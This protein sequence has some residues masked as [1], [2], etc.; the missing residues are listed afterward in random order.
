MKTRSAALMQAMLDAVVRA[1]AAGAE[2]GLTISA[3][4]VAFGCA[5]VT[6]MT[7]M[8]DLE[9]RDLVRVIGDIA[10]PKG[11]RRHQVYGPTEIAA[12]TKLPPSFATT[13]R[14]QK[15]PGSVAP[16]AA[17][18][19]PIVFRPSRPKTQSGSGVVA[20]KKEIRGYV[21]HARAVQA[22]A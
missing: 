8:K 20:G 18:A 22:D 21:W 17:I 4:Q 6:A 16:V 13:A 5:Y 15:R 3:L 7:Y 11:G 14:W 1:G 9:A 2:C 19:P 10:G 12:T